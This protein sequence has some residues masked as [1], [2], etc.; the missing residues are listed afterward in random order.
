M[1]D[2]AAGLDALRAAW[3]R[4]RFN[5]HVFNTLE[6]YDRVIGREYEELTSGPLVFRMH[7]EERAVLQRY[8]PQTLRRAWD[9]MVRRYGFT[10]QGPVRIELFATTRHFSVRTTGLPNVGV[11]GVCFGQVVT[12]LSP[13]AG[14]FNGGQITWHELAHVFHIQMSRNHVPRWFTEGLSEY[15]TIVARPEWRREDDG[16]LRRALETGR[17]PP[18]RDLNFAF[19]HARTSDDM[20]VA[21]YASSQVV[22]YLVE[23]FGFEK[24]PDMLRAWGAGRRTEDVVQRVLGISIDQLDRDFRDHTRRRLASRPPDFAV[25]FGAYVDLAAARARAAQAPNDADAQAGLAA[26][27]IVERDARGALAAAQRALQLRADQPIARFILARAALA[28]NDVRTGEQHLRALIVR[29]D[30][31]EP[32]LLLARIALGR[33]DS[34]AARTELQA[35]T[36]ID[37]AR[38]EAWQGLIE[39]AREANDQE[40]LLA[41]RLELARIDQHDRENSAALLETLAARNRWPDVVTHGEMAL[42]LDPHRSETHRLLGEAYLRTNRADAA[43]YEL[44]TALL[45]TPERP[46]PIHLARARALLA[47]GRRPEAQRAAREA[48]RADPT[49]AAEARTLLQ[50]PP[51]PRRP[52]R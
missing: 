44:D 20:M 48:Q 12:A 40:A 16:A 47:L 18:L 5:V 14:S 21:Y 6:L 43:L 36:R 28:Q 19:T 51:P 35:A 38:P 41:A 17:L 1:G 4:D 45:A 13:R 31:Y 9:D 11:Q 46:G 33:H 39:L 42:H 22:V 32:R 7:R 27:L 34:A 8:V 25:D 30:G 50:Q 24:V 3:Q 15:E 29:H 52:P 37:R 26:A 2:E 10:P 23:R 49:L